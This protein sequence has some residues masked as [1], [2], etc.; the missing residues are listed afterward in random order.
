[1]RRLIIGDIHARYTLLRDVLDKAG[2][3][4]DEDILYSVGDFC[5]RGD[6]PYETLRY[7][8]GL[9]DFRP[10]LGNHDAWLEY[11]L[12]NNE[13][14]NNW[15]IRNGGHTTV[16]GLADRPS[17][18]LSELQGWLAE[19]PIIRVEEKDIIVHGGFSEEYTEKELRN[20][21][22]RKRPVPLFNPY[23]DFGSFFM[24][25]D[26]PG[27]DDEDTD[28]LEGFYWDRNYLLSAMADGNDRTFGGPDRMMRPISTGKTIWI[29]HTQLYKTARPFYSEKYHLRAIDTGAGSGLGKLTVVDMDTTEY[30]QSGP[31][32]KEKP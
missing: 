30:W 12:C 17:A 29:G 18:W 4:P 21:A 32:G 14:D 11:W 3:N 5:D 28:Y 6:K 20:I 22:A 16:A 31:E 13:I 24:E 8:M 7:L 15:Y 23:P 19:I 2:F 25:D 9:K 26:E 27:L 1:M 10:V